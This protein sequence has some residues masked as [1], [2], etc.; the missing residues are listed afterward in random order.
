MS[1]EAAHRPSA[2]FRRTSGHG[3][4]R[5]GEQIVLGA[6]PLVVLGL[7]F[8]FLV[9]HN[10]LGV[11]FHYVYYPAVLR[12]LHGGDPY[13]V[14]HRELV[15][16]AAFVYPA[17]SLVVF[18]PLGLI[19]RGAA[20]TIYVVTCLACVP[21]TLR[22][23]NVRDWR[24][25]GITLLWLPVYAGWQSGN[26]TLPLVLLVALAWRYRDRPVVVGAISAVA[27]SIK[28]FV[29]PLALWLL[30]TRRVRATAWTLAWAVGINL[31][32][33]WLVGF[34][35]ISAYVRV[36]GQLTDALWRG[37]YSML[38]VAHHLGLGRG[39]GDLLLFSGSAALGLA[40]LYLGAYRHDERAALTATV[41]LMLVASPL[42][43][44]HYFALLLVPMALYRPRLD[45]LWALP[46]LMWPLPPTGDLY[47]WQIVLGWALAGACL[48]SCIR[49]L[50]PAVASPAGGCPRALQILRTTM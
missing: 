27:I 18:A 4:G 5:A 11:D 9:D 39:A 46:V 47:D 8:L 30:A 48:A 37:G 44:S 17:L 10:K 25:Y 31:V 26:V 50:R 28:P 43:R 38:A 34:R 29:W 49:T 6:V 7:L 14:T 1:I 12:W 35:E 32:A 22:V 3:L 40:I 13:Q 19:G 36:S 21:A 2:A 41:A 33:W 24:V 45:W 15:H 42:V 23:L 20:E 16:A